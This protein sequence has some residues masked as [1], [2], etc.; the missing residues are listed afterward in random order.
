[1]LL[2]GISTYSNNS[3]LWID[4]IFFMP[5]KYNYWNYDFIIF[6][7]KLI[8]KIKITNTLGTAWRWNRPRQND[9]V[10]YFTVLTQN[11]INLEPTLGS[12]PN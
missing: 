9:I 11:Q 8:F 2:K 4:D 3:I 7:L 12:D 10:T 5:L 6:Y 1:M